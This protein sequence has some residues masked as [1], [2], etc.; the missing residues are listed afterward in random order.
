MAASAV[1]TAGD[2]GA[3]GGSGAGAASAGAAAGAATTRTIS[4]GRGSGT[5][6]VANGSKVTLRRSQPGSSQR[7]SLRSCPR[8]TSVTTK[9]EK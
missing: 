9:F 2:G 8:N 5:D 6:S 4:S 3:T 7:T 1:A